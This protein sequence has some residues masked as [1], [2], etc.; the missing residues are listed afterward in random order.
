MRG[1]LI[2]L[3]AV[4]SAAAFA[5]APVGI[6]IGMSR[7]DTLAALGA[8]TGYFD[9]GT[10]LRTERLPVATI[11]PLYE[12]FTRKT[13]DNEFELNIRFQE[14]PTGS[15]L[16]PTLRIARAFVRFDKPVPVKTVLLQSPEVAKLCLE[17]CRLQVFALKR[18]EARGLRPTAAVD[19]VEICVSDQ[20]RT[21][22]V[23]LKYFDPSG[24]EQNM[25]GMDAPVSEMEIEPPLDLSSPA[26]ESK[27]AGAW[28][29]P[30]P[31]AS[32]P[33]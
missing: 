32:P 16:H 15:R 8:P 18:L 33:Q 20:A 12:V 28:R 31:P 30:Q 3:I 24:K 5:Q 2:L 7:E 11:G 1:Y 27:D 22:S 13:A 23:V 25:I 4:G 19:A 21:E 10:Q 29:T 26:V 17:G 9:A 6:G 14:D